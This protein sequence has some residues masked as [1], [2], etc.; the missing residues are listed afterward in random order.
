MKVCAEELVDEL[1]EERPEDLTQ[2]QLE[3]TEEKEPL[4]YPEECFHNRTLFSIYG[5]SVEHPMDWLIFFDPKRPFNQSTGYFRIEDYVPRKGA[6]LSLSINWEKVPCDNAS[7]AIQY[8]ENIAEQYRRQFRKEP[9]TIEYLDLIDY[10]NGKAAFLVSE[11]GANLGIL[12][13]KAIDRVRI[14]QLAFYDEHSGRAVVGSVI[15]RPGLIREKEER[16]K[17]FLFTLKCS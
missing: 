14:L 11:H 10:L 13:K 16:L 17:E 15:G 4:E 5:V 1:K 8:G 7:F 6:N 12:R 3:D 9:Y 2:E